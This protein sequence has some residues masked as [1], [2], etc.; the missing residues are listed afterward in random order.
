M[1]KN[2]VSI[3]D[4]KLFEILRLEKNRIELQKLESNF[5]NLLAE[6]IKK[7][8]EKYQEQRKSN[9]ETINE[10]NLLGTEIYNINKLTRDIYFRRLRKILNL[11][12]N[13]S[14]AP[15]TVVENSA[16]LDIEKEF[17]ELVKKNFQDN[18]KQVLDKILSGSVPGFAG[19][20]QD[21]DTDNA[22]KDNSEQK[23]EENVPDNNK[24]KNNETVQV[25]FI[26]DVQKFVGA[27][28][29]FYGPFHPKDI[30]K[31]PNKIVDILKSKGQVEVLSN[32]T[33][34]K[35]LESFEKQ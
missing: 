27:D 3:T 24:P 9:N 19:T 13:F 2:E 4:E 23:P 30:A 12:L 26:A 6:Y 5:Y 34:G 28:L 17:F 21:A 31:L 8:K 1:D 20:F 15:D 33:T 22:K 18:K 29:E 7:K 25:R 16:M 11:A 14:I 10:N 32:N 35:P